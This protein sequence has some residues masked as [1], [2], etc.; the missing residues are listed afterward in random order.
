MISGM[1]TGENVLDENDGYCNKKTD[2]GSWTQEVV[3]YKLT[4]K[5]YSGLGKNPKKRRKKH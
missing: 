1:E 2:I 4:V 3:H 5:C